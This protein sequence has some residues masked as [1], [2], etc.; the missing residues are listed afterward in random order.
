VKQIGR[1]TIAV[2][3]ARRIGRHRRMAV[4]VNPTA[5]KPPELVEAVP[6]R[7]E[8]GL[9]AEVPLPD[10]ASCISSRGE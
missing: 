8:L 2:D 7:R 6:A 1:Q 10:K 3:L 9:R 4:I 5:E